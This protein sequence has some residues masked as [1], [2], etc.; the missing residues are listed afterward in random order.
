M[1]Y[2][3]IINEVWRSVSEYLNYQVSNIGRVRNSNTFIILKPTTDQYGYYYVSLS[4]NGKCTNHLIHRLVGMEF[5]VPPETDD[6]ILIDHIDSDKQNNRITNLRVTD[7][8]KQ[9]KE[10]NNNYRKAIK[11]IEECRIDECC[12]CF[13]TL[14]DAI[15][16]CGHIVCNKCIHKL[17]RC[18]ICR[19]PFYAREGLRHIDLEAK[20]EAVGLHLSMSDEDLD[21]EIVSVDGKIV[22]RR[23]QNCYC[24]DGE[25]IIRCHIWTIHTLTPFS[26]AEVLDA[27][28]SQDFKRECNHRFY[29]G[30][31]FDYEDKVWDI[32]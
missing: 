25:P 28:L 8:T 31:H 2:Q 13:E 26:N 18:P 7:I 12:V 24:F 1:N 17:D 14:P 3:V 16:G 20:A 29:E 32:S 9:M 21:A 4:K 30:L 15:M 11:L 22:L 6:R 23:K 19:A 5:L 27:L 10:G